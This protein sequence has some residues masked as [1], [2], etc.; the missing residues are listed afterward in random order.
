MQEPMEEEGM[1]TR[2]HFRR[3]VATAALLVVGALT[4]GASAGMAAQHEPKLGLGYP[5]QSPADAVTAARDVQIRDAAHMALIQNARRHGLDVRNVQPVESRPFYIHSQ[6]AKLPSVGTP[7]VTGGFSWTYP[8][9]LAALALAL[10]LLAGG[11]V[12]VSR[13]VKSRTVTA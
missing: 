2:S 13:R 6:S 1:Q 3:L 12:L 11:L 5:R 9:V 10:A 7:D 8:R 4:F